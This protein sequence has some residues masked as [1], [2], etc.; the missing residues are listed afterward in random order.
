MFP[1]KVSLMETVKV[2]MSRVKMGGTDGQEKGWDEQVSLGIGID[3]CIVSTFYSSLNSASAVAASLC[4]V[5]Y[6]LFD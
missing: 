6:S 1:V 3:H 5:I 2:D 4:S